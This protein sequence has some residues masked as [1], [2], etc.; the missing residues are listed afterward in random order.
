MRGRREEVSL[1]QRE[2]QTER[3]QDHLRPDD[4]GVG[5]LRRREAQEGAGRR[6]DEGEAEGGRVCQV[7]VGFQRVLNERKKFDFKYISYQTRRFQEYPRGRL[8]LP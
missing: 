3:H 6:E 1:V 7:Q 5:Q 4:E 2:G 8:G